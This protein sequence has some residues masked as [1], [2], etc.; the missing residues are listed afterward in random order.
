M[1]MCEHVANVTRVTP[2]SEGC[3]ECLALGDS[4]FHLRLCLTCGHVGCCDTSKNKHATAHFRATG[5][6]VVQSFQPDEEWV[7][8]YVDDLFFDRVPESSSPPTGQ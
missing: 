5:H 8:C 4:W 1:D 3:Q 2:V 7:W 6:P